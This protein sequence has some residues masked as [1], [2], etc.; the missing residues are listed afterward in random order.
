MSQDEMFAQFTEGLRNIFRE[1]TDAALA[2][3]EGIARSF[4]I[5]MSAIEAE[6]TSLRTATQPRYAAI[7]ERLAAVELKVLGER[8]D[9]P[10]Q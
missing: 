10:Q 1:Y 8:R 4:D 2:G 5:R 3:L 7:E 6:L 9:F